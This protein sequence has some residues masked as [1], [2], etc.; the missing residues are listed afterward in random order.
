[1]LEI[2]VEFDVVELYRF[3]VLETPQSPVPAALS[4]LCLF[5]LHIPD[6]VDVSNMK[7]GLMF[8]EFE[9]LFAFHAE[10]S[11]YPIALTSNVRM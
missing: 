9:R 6:T 4:P 3:T 11:Q 10:P 5:K 7:T 1:M 8:G 2:S